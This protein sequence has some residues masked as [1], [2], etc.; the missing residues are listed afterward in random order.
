MIKQVVLKFGACGYADPLVLTTDAVTVFVGPNNS[1]KSLALREI[2]N[3]LN[4]GP[5]GKRAIVER[6]EVQWPKPEEGLARLESR[7][8]EPS[9]GQKPVPVGSF[10]VQKFNPASGQIEQIDVNESVLLR[11][12]QT[13]WQAQQDGRAQDTVNWVGLFSHF[14][15]LFTIALDG[16]TRF[17]LTDQRSAGDLLGPPQ[18]HLAALFVDEAARATV[19][20]IVR[21]ALGLYFVIDPTHVGQLRVRMSSRGPVDTA[22]EQS[23]DIRARTFHGE[24][25][26]IATLSDG[27][28]AFTGIVCALMSS[29][30]NVMLVDEPEAF[31]HPPL[32]RKLGAIMASIG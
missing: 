3:Y 20:E 10:R 21:E 7:K 8:I 11:S 27:V 31:L 16:R 14:L 1:G 26:D 2:F 13:E 22:E 6:I 32:A 15:S 30:Y 18:N 23:F 12:L 24:A 5:D 28:K 4:K 17:A 25:A 29:D 9:Q 19:R